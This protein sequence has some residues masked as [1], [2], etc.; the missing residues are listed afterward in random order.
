MNTLTPHRTLLALVLSTS[1]G[2][3][4][5]APTDALADLAKSE[6]SLHSRTCGLALLSDGRAQ[7]R[8]VKASSAPT[9]G[10]QASAE[11]LTRAFFLLNDGS[12]LRGAPG[13]RNLFKELAPAWK[14]SSDVVEH[15]ETWF[16]HRKTQSDFDMTDET[17]GSVAQ[18]VELTFRTE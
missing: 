3:A 2:A 18:Q 16:E 9:L 14:V 15:C 12:A 7:V 4:L 10:A 11:Q 1:L 13:P 17:R 8:E 6:R 5:A